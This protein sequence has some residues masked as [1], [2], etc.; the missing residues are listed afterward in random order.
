M[1]SI[2]LTDHDLV[3]L[4]I[5]L[6]ALGFV[7]YK[8]VKYFSNKG[9]EANAH[10]LIRE[11]GNH[12]GELDE[13]LK[14]ISF[15]R[16]VASAGL[17]VMKGRRE[18]IRPQRQRLIAYSVASEAYFQFGRR[19]RSEANDLITR[20]FMRDQLAGF[21]DMRTT[22]KVAIIEMALA[23]S[24]VPPSI[25]EEVDDFVGTNAYSSVVNMDRSIPRA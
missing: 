21:K 8:V 9:R 22:D 15:G 14:D 2:T 18:R 11:F 12:D 10:A 3:I 20:K 23:F 4:C 25:C 24:Y 19:R 5:C 17:D 16:E 6:G 13:Q 7:I 1:I